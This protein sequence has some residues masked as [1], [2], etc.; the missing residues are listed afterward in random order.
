MILSDI[1]IADAIAGGLIKI[2]PFDEKC[3]GPN[4]YDVHLSDHL[5]LYLPKLVHESVPVAG[6]Q[7]WAHRA[8]R[9]LDCR[10][11]QK[12]TRSEIGPSGA[13]LKPGI[14]YLASTLEYTETLAHVPYLDGKSSVGRL[15]I[16]VHVT[17]G[18][19]DIGFRGHW[20]LEIT[21]VHPIRVYAGMPIGQLTY[22][23]VQSQ[24]NVPYDKRTGGAAYNNRDPEPQPSRMWKNFTK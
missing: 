21:V 7:E 23:M 16:S 10:D 3:L 11:E 17:A 20:T 4:S 13:I 5:A 19:G 9:M 14:L 15:G 1:D 22:H 18:R 8:I 12:V 2:E 24:P 6:T